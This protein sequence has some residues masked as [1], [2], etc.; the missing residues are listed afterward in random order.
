MEMKLEEK[1]LWQR[2]ARAKRPSMRDEIRNELVVLYLWLARDVTNYYSRRLPM[3]V[4]RQDL[5]SEAS[6]GLMDAIPRFDLSRKIAPTTFLRFRITGRV[7]DWLRNLD[8]VSRT[9]RRKLNQLA[10]A[11]EELGRSISN[12]EC[13][14]SLGFERP[15]MAPATI[16]IFRES[17]NGQR[18]FGRVKTIAEQIPESR[19]DRGSLQDCGYLLKGL[20]QRERLIVLLYHVQQVPM[21]Q[22]GREV[23]M[24]ESRIS[25]LMP[26]ILARV[27]DNAKRHEDLVGRRQAA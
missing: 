18:E 12:D 17:H 27:R 15:S 1:R 9:H 4:C 3:H 23:G 14:E 25:Q 13:K 26:G 10:H 22:V 24:S 21:K 8:D 11:E 16:S 19:P 2:L 5:E 7:I 6:I 20:S